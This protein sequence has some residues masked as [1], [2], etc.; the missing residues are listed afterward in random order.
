[1]KFFTL[2]GFDFSQRFSS[3]KKNKYFTYWFEINCIF[4]GE[5][6]Y[7]ISNDILSLIRR[8]YTYRLFEHLNIFDEIPIFFEVIDEKIYP[9]EL[10]KLVLLHDEFVKLLNCFI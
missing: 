1:L 7:L 4:I 9:L 8:A 10:D 3:S 2:D 6:S 5:T